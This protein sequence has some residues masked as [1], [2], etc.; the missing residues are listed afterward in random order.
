MKVVIRYL[1][2]NPHIINIAKKELLLYQ[3]QKSR[4]EQSQPTRPCLKLSV[5][6][7]CVFSRLGYSTSNK[8]N[9]TTMKVIL[10]LILLM[11]QGYSNGLGVCEVNNLGLQVMKH[12]G[13]QGFEFTSLHKLSKV[14]ETSPLKTA[15]VWLIKFVKKSDT[16]QYINVKIQIDT[17]ERN[18]K[19]DE[20]YNKDG[21]EVYTEMS[22]YY[23]YRELGIKPIPRPKSK[24]SLNW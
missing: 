17:D 6:F 14:L 5:F 2:V 3:L 10:F 24:P 11:T 9:N 16:G 23:A 20:Y 22:V 19:V 1:M 8:N 12:R 18:I 7:Q 15:D 4:N 21:Q 13:K